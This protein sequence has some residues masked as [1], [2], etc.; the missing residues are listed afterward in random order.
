MTVLLLH[1]MPIIGSSD[2]QHDRSWQNSACCAVHNTEA[3]HDISYGGPGDFVAAATSSV[4]TMEGAVYV[5]RVLSAAGISARNLDA[6]CAHLVDE[7]FDTPQALATATTPD[8]TGAGLSRSD[9]RA[10]LR[11]IGAESAVQAPA[12]RRNLPK[13]A[14]PTPARR[15]PKRRRGSNP[16][17]AAANTVDAVAGVAPAGAAARFAVVGTAAGGETLKQIVQQAGHDYRKG[18]SGRPCEVLCSALMR[19][20]C[21]CAPGCALYEVVKKEKVSAT[22]KIVVQVQSTGEF[23]YVGVCR[24]RCC[25]LQIMVGLV[26]EMTSHRPSWLLA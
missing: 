22:K 7:G 2:R 17:P 10:F 24:L 20:V 11:H 18:C 13:K 5:K 19:T 23:V 9:A 15:V 4:H 12:Q 3:P 14:D 25:G 6:I 1:H 16:A 26:A 21:V 8:L